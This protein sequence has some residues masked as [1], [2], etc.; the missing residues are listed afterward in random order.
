MCVYVM[1]MSIHLI[2]DSPDDDPSIGDVKAIVDSGFS[3][4]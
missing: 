2:L 1:D 3:R 4:M